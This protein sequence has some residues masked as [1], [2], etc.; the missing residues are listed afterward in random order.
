M[1][2]CMQVL[3]SDSTDRSLKN[4]YHNCLWFICYQK[5]K[6]KLQ[7]YATLYAEITVYYKAN[8]RIN[9]DMKYMLTFNRLW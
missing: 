7:Q 1:S 8:Y 4:S 2:K 3:K 9:M 5:K 6:K